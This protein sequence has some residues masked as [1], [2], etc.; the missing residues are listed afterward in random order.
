M[1]LPSGLVKLMDFGIAQ[2]EGGR[3]LA[4]QS[5]FRVGTPNYMSPEQ[6]QDAVVAARSDIYSAGAVMFEMFTG[7]TPFVAEDPFKVMQMHVSSE[8]P[9]PSALRP[10]LPESLER[11]I[12]ACLAKQPVRRPASAQDLHG[13]LLRIR[14]PEE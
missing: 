14:V 12:L 9:R 2:T 11:L 7:R 6:T 13:A 5:G 3:D 10:D 1:V 8:P 4:S